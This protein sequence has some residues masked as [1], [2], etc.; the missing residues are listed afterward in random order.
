M[1]T[2]ERFIELW[3]DHL[4]GELD[5]LLEADKSTQKSKQ[6]FTLTGVI[7][8]GIGFF[9]VIVSWLFYGNRIQLFAPQEHQSLIGCDPV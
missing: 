5:E 8:A 4:E 7:L 9:F 3:N 1:S 6:D 2:D